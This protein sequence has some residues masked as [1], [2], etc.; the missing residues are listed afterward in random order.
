M[1]S[2]REEFE[3]INMKQLGYEARQSAIDAHGEANLPSAEGAYSFVCENCEAFNI[4]PNVIAMFPLETPIEFERGYYSVHPLAS[5]QL[6]KLRNLIAC[7]E[8]EI[9]VHASALDVD[10]NTC[11]EYVEL[12]SIDDVLLDMQAELLHR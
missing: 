7:R 6:T 3:N 2:A 9:A 8:R 12:E 11:R 5:D 1:I 10:I 4:A